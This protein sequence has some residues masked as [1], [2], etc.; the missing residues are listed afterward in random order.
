MSRP[1][2]RATYTSNPTRRNLL[3]RDVLSL[4]RRACYA[5]EDCRTGSCAATR[6]PFPWRATGHKG[7]RATADYGKPT[8]A[9]PLAL[10]GGRVCHESLARTGPQEAAPR[11]PATGHCGLR[12]LRE[13]VAWR[14]VARNRAISGRPGS[15]QRTAAL[16]GLVALEF[17]LRRE[18]QDPPT[19]KEYVKRFPGD[20][21]IVATA[22]ATSNQTPAVIHRRRHPI[23]PQLEETDAVLT[24]SGVGEST[25][26]VGGSDQS[27]DLRK[28]IP[29]RLGRYQVV[30]L[31]GEGSLGRATSLATAS[32]HATWRSRSRRNRRLALPGRLEA[33]LAEARMAAS[34]RHRRSSSAFTTSATLT[35][36][37]FSSSSSSSKGA[38]SPTCWGGARS[39]RLAGP[40]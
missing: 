8:G 34:L 3:G 40:G 25:I 27:E 16:H 5:G 18:E 35:T 19:L 30:R 2:P 13:C 24:D 37:Q 10:D 33:L 29:P 11:H 31:L 20:A 28:P 17:K 12:T 7:R 22:F 1:P 39:R 32:S 6:R 14:R 23:G 21:T 38:P 15:R 26:A 9:D 4:A 36:A